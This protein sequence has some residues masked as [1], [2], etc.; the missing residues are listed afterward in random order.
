[1][2][3]PKQKVLFGG[4]GFIS[5]RK[6]PRTRIFHE[7]PPKTTT[8][9][10]D[11]LWE[12]SYMYA[13][14]ISMSYDIGTVS[15]CMWQWYFI[16]VRIGYT[17]DE[18]HEMLPVCVEM[19]AGIGNIGNIGNIGMTEFDEIIEFVKSD[20]L[21]VEH[22][23]Q[24]ED[25]VMQME[26]FWYL[27]QQVFEWLRGFCHMCWYHGVCHDTHIPWHVCVLNTTN[28]S[29]QDM[30][31]V[32]CDMIWIDLSIDITLWKIS[33]WCVS[34]WIR[35]LFSY[36]MEWLIECEECMHVHIINKDMLS[37]WHQLHGYGKRDNLNR[38]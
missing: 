8:I 16:S 6:V 15:K 14:I 5:W 13:M 34:E 7:H 28:N 37:K 24:N 31:V 35:Y 3:P 25:H 30:C 21:L 38:G 22:M 17:F 19:I 4:W 23:E 32:M 33:S 1:M 27:S 29:L 26:T 9:L 18:M 20:S 12:M 2:V 11:I 10:F 36:V